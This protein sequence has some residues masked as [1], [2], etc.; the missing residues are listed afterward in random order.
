MKVTRFVN[1]VLSSNTYIIYK[2]ESP[3]VWVLDPGD[4]DAIFRWVS[5]NEKTI[6]G[7]LLTHYHVD[8][9]YG[10][11]ELLGKEKNIVIYASNLSK[12]GLESSKLNGSLYLDMP[13]TVKNNVNFVRE[14]QKLS[15]WHDINAV[16]YNTPGHNNDCISYHIGNGLF[17]GDAMIPGVRI[18]LKSKLADKFEAIKTIDWIKS[19]FNGNTVIYPGHKESCLLKDFTVVN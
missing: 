17:V 16:V 4:S 11:N 13:I 1:S 2:D 12:D 7:I 8:H 3:D 18:H 6:Q 15:L 5:D 14:G 10:V 19:K 9:I